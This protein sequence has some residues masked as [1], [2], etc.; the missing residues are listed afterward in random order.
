MT[1]T[2]SALLALGTDAPHFK[3][4]NTVSNQMEDL[5]NLKGKFGTV[6]MFICN[7]CPFVIHVNPEITRIAK[8]YT[9]KG[10]GFIAISSNDSINYPQESLDLMKEK[11]A[12]EGYS[13]QYLYD[14]TQE[15]VK[16]YQAACTPDFYL[17]VADLKLVDRGQLDDSGPENGVPLNG[18][19]LRAAMDSFLA[20]KQIATRQKPSIGC[21]S[22]R[23]K[24]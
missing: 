8:K 1:R 15:V 18:N 11:V 14:Q 22:K 13:L 24:N 2:E 23:F 10:I 17:F 19:D 7:H 12:E 3:L 6:I 20:G 4:F 21:S 9:A 16:A 5:N